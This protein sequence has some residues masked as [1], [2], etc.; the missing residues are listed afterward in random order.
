MSHSGGGLGCGSGATKLWTA[1]LALVHS[2]AEYSFLH[3][4]AV[5][6]PTSLILSWSMPCRLWLD[7]CVL[8]TIHQQTIFLSLWHPICWASLQRSHTIASTPCHGAWSSASLSAHLSTEWE[9]TAS[10]IEM[11]ICT[12]YLSIHLWTATE[13]W[14]CGQITRWR[15][16]C[17]ENNKGLHIFIPN[18]DTYSPGIAKNSVG[19]A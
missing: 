7:A 3:G 13:V 16:Q 5:V 8:H 6:T 9:C 18:N 17:L 11:P 2:T 19:L 12:C 15:T 1:T 10:Q 4:A 14:R